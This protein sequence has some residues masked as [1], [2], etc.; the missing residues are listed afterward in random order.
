MNCL[1]E[2]EKHGGFTE[3]EHARKHFSSQ[4]NQLAIELATKRIFK[5]LALAKLTILDGNKNGLFQSKVFV[6]ILL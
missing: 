2:R 4:P 6:L 3:I 1:S 5:D